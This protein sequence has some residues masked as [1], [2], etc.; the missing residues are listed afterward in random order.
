MVKPGEFTSN[1][2]GSQAR[3]SVRT[4]DLIRARTGKNGG[5]RRTRKVSNVR[6]YLALN[7]RTPSVR[8]L[9]GLG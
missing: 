6:P 7:E 3:L 2:L 9:G 8:A 1:P 4:P 5:A